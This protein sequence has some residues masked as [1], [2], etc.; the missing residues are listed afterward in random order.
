MFTTS[1]DWRLAGC[2]RPLPLYSSPG[3][4][5]ALAPQLVWRSSLPIFC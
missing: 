3:Q 2:G 5:R 1:G 4:L